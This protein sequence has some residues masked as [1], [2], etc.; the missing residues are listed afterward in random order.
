[1]SNRK[2]ENIPVR[3][4]KFLSLIFG[5]IS[6]FFLPVWSLARRHWPV[7][8]VEKAIPKFDP[9]TWQLTIAGLIENEISLTYL[10]LKN[11]PSLTQVTD[12]DCVEKWS[13]RKIKWQG[14]QLKTII[15]MA[16]PEPAAK[17]LTINCMEGAYSESLS[18]NQALATDVIL[19]YAADD[20]PLEPEHGGPL[21]LVVPNLWGYKSAKWVERI[22][23]VNARHLGYWE[24]RGYDPDSGPKK[25]P[26][27]KN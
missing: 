22:E 5:A 16:K 24:Q 14:V 11:L 20:K 4:R 18:L 8:T 21:R 10:E 15:E 23:F 19:A 1:M 3:R 6:A 7:R 12:L 17:F 26:N 2:R 27:K 13:V 25:D 9:E